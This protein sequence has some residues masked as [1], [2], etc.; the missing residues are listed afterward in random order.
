MIGDT[1]EPCSPSAPKWRPL[2]VPVEHRG[3]S[4]RLERVLLEHRD[5]SIG[6]ATLVDRHAANCLRDGGR[7]LSPEQPLRQPRQ[8]EEG[9]VE[10]TPALHAIAHELFPKARRMRR[11][12]D[13]RRSRRTRLPQRELHATSHPIVATSVTRLCRRVDQARDVGNSRRSGARPPWAWRTSHSRA[14]SAHHAV[15]ELA[16]AQLMTHGKRAPKDVEQQRE[17]SCVVAGG[18]HSKGSPGRRRARWG[19]HARSLAA[20]TESSRWVPAQRE[21]ELRL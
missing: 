16:T 4:A 19:A 8:L 14:G 1:A 7:T 10:R 3:E 17:P 20:L 11:I 9:R 6:E 2:A 18:L 15:A 12:Q 5:H 21:K 13:T